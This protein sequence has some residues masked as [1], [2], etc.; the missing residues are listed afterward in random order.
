MSDSDYTSSKES[1]SESD[2]SLDGEEYHEQQ[3]PD[4]HQE[5]LHPPVERIVY[6]R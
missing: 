6:R 2:V 5:L 4:N 3:L 1:E